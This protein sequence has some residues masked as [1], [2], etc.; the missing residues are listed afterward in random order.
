MPSSAV[1]GD[2]AGSA[3]TRAGGEVADPVDWGLAVRIARRVAGRE[4]L[5]A[6]YLA[7]SLRHD[8]SDVTVEAER[9][10]TEF[11]GLRPSGPA[12]GTVLDRGGWV[13]A[14][15][16]SLRTLL[17]PLTARVGERMERS[18]LAP[19]G[20]RI[21]GTEMGVLLGYVAKRVLGQ[22]D[23]LVPEDPERPPTDDAV[24]FVG[25]NVLALEKR[26]AFRPRDFR[27]WIAIHELTH[28]AQFT[29]V[30]WMRPYFLSLVERSLSLVEPDPSRLL[31]V[32]GRIAEE[33][34]EGRNPLDDGGLVGLLA[35]PEQQQLLARTQALMSLLEGHGNL[36]MNHLGRDHVAGQARMAQVLQARRR[37]R[38]LTAMVQKLLGLELKMRQ[39]E[40]GERFCLGV[41]REAGLA[42]L[43]AAW[44]SPEHLPTLEELDRPSEWLARVA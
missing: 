1:V 2:A 3:A 25:P 40:V 16:A 44:R 4:P 29:G 6:S 10:V 35:T 37:A 32:L 30:P 23:L 39:Y 36:V 7:D 5:A 8:F 33:L 31:R 12:N 9:L 43:D 24:Y 34:R 19:V 41:E 15:V 26:F 22:Y 38:G 18:P 21:A 28:R 42:A 14:N 27:L 13:E 17:A 11:T 20:R